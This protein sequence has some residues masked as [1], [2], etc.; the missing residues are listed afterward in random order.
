MPNVRDTAILGYSRQPG[1]TTFHHSGWQRVT[2]SNLLS[3][4]KIRDTKC[5]N[6]QL[7]I[8]GNFHSPHSHSRHIRSYIKMVGH[9]QSN[10]YQCYTKILPQELDKLF[11]QLAGL[12]NSRDLE[13]FLNQVSN[14]HRLAPVYF[15]EISFCPQCWYACVRVCPPLRALITSRP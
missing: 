7:C 14:G 9:W 8:W 10:T 3:I 5:F 2:S 12:L 4:T 6:M 15:L 1:W 13:L 11:K